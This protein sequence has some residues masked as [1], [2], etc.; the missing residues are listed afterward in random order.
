MQPIR[1]HLHVHGVSKIWGAF[2]EINV[3]CLGVGIPRLSLFAWEVG[4]FPAPFPLA[5]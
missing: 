1:K 5:T 3:D 4:H 2:T